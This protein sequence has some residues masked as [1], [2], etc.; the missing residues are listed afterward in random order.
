[1]VFN[2]GVYK[3]KDF[4]IPYG[5]GQME[6]HGCHRTIFPRSGD[7]I[8]NL[9]VGDSFRNRIINYNTPWATTNKLYIS[10]LYSQGALELQQNGK[11]A[12]YAI[13]VHPVIGYHLLK[14]PMHE[15]VDKQVQISHLLETEGVFLRNIEISEKITSLNDTHLR[16]FFSSILPEKSK[17][18]LDPIY[19]AVNFIKNRDGCVGIHELSSRFCMSERTLNRHF[20]LKVGLSAQAYA[21][22]W[23]IEHTMRLIQIYPQSS[24]DEIAFKAG[25]YDTAHLARDFREKAGLAPSSFR[26]NT[27][28]MTKDYLK[29]QRFSV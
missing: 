23:K 27:S 7:L 19:H 3:I 17:Y 25:Y 22:I 12:A 14:L 8:L 4:R 29:T 6:I 2:L 28:P 13:K 18:I 10:G 16:D 15:L 11:G 24:L 21:K 20:L 9:Y 1:M 5:L 26:K